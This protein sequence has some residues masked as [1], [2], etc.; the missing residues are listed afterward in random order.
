MIILSVAQHTR[1]LL[2]FKGVA[3]KMVFQERCS[4][5]CPNLSNCGFSP[6]SWAKSFNLVEFATQFIIIII[7]KKIK[8][9]FSPLKYPQF[10]RLKI[11][12]VLKIWHKRTKQN[13]GFRLSK[14]ALEKKLLSFDLALL[15]YSTILNRLLQACGH[16][17]QNQISC[18]ND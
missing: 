2:F 17:I 5:I 13:R 3:L 11:A 9:I 6:N 4:Y 10:F 18:K 15:F 12:S 14:N 16:I 8:S 1:Y 7:K